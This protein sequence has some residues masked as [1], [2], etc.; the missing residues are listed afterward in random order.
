MVCCG[1]RCPAVSFST[2]PLQIPIVGFVV[3]IVDGN[4]DGEMERASELRGRKGELREN[5]R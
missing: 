3:L 5:R 2:Q 4:R 1:L